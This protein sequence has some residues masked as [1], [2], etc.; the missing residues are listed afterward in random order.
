M[1]LPL[2]NFKFAEGGFASVLQTFVSVRLVSTS[3]AVPSALI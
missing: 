1:F 2:M 3:L